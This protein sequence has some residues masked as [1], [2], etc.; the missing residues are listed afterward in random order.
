MFKVTDNI[1]QIELDKF[2]THSRWRKNAQISEEQ[3]D[4]AWRGVVHQ[5]VLFTQ[6]SA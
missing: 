1:S 3:C 4:V 6:I 2:I 5:R